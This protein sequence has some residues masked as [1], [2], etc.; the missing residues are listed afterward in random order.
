MIKG[1]SIN[2]PGFNEMRDPWLMALTVGFVSFIGDL[3]SLDKLQDAPVRN[4][5]GAENSIFTFGLSVDI[6]I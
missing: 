6:S 5:V 3:E 1:I 2:Q 4:S